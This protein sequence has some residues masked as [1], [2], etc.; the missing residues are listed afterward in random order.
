MIGTGGAVSDDDFRVRMAP[1]GPFETAPHLA[2][3]VSGGSDSMA[4]AVLADAWC[5]ARGG[6]VTA[7]TVDHGLRTAS[8]GETRRVSAWMARRG[9]DHAVLPW[10]GPKPAAGVQAA[11]RDARYRL[12]ERWCRDHGVLHLLLGHTADDQA[13]T[14]LLRLRRGSNATGLAGMPAVRELRHCRILRPLLDLRRENIRKYLR[15][16]GQDWIED[17]SNDDARYARTAVRRMIAAGEFSTSALCRSA[18]DYGRARIVAEEAA[19]AFLSRHAR[20]H[21]AGFARVERAGVRAAADDTALRG[22]GRVISSIGATRHAPRT[23]GLS[24]LLNAVRGGAE[25]SRTLGRCRIFSDRDDVVFCRE[26]RNLPAESPVPPGCEF[27]WDHRIAVSS[28]EDISAD[29]T[30]RTTDSSGWSDRARSSEDFTR[31]RNLP[32]PVRE[33]LPV[34][35]GPT[36]VFSAPLL[37][38]NPGGPEGQNPTGVG[39]TFRPRRSPPTRFCV[40]NLA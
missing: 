40:A 13:E 33:S 39:M 7:L 24:A 8:A 9:I 4:L 29:L 28:G 35:A 30:I 18:A 19:D 15:S 25:L 16:A 38:Y 14:F 1:F 12:M 3:A 32:R 23:R 20:L 36:G 6:R 31:W 21:P 27:V 10:R 5:R 11:A 22:L 2:V 26:A 34:L 37:T 17:P